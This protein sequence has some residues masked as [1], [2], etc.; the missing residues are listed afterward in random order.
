MRLARGWS[1]DDLA[2]ESRLTVETVA[3]IEDGTGGSLEDIDA[4]FVALDAEVV[5]VLLPRQMASFLGALQPVAGR[6]SDEDLPLVQAEIMRTI[7]LAA[8]KKPFDEA[9][10]MNVEA[11][12]IARD[13][14]DIEQHIHKDGLLCP[15][16]GG[17]N[18]ATVGAYD[19]S[20]MTYRITEYD[21]S[22]IYRQNRYPVV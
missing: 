8:A 3:A 19:S 22:D 2:E 11:G 20:R 21:S 6:I 4:I 18:L 9:S 12:V 5:T 16:F 13:D 10:Q 15:P 7:G 17:R 1:R 14:A